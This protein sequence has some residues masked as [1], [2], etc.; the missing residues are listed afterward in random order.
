MHGANIQDRDG[1]KGVLQRSRSRLS[2]VE[3]AY[4]DGG[5]TGLLVRWAKDRIHIVLQVVKRSAERVGFAVIQRR[6]VVERT[7]A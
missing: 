1:A 7:F 4:M 2:F 6:W 5:Y 3:L